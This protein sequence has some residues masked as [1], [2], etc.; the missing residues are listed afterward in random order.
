MGAQ[1]RPSTQWAGKEPSKLALRRSIQCNCGRSCRPRPATGRMQNSR[2]RFERPTPRRALAAVGGSR[3]QRTAAK[4][5][6]EETLAKHGKPGQLDAESGSPILP[7]APWSCVAIN[8]HAD[9]TLRAASHGSSPPCVA[10]CVRPGGVRRGICRRPLRER[11]SLGDGSLRSNLRLPR[12]AAVF[13][14][15]TLLDRARDTISLRATSRE[16]R[17]C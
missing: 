1:A 6:A 5:W 11:C 12:P 17:R 15:H 13:F 16:V 3:V 4:T 2:L 10:I 8:C 7:V 14:A 9:E